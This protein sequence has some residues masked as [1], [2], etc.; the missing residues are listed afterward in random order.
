MRRIRFHQ[1]SKWRAGDDLGADPRVV[2]GEQRLVVDQDVA[3][4]GPVLELLDLVE[5]RPVV[6][7]ERV[8]GPPVALDQR[9][10]DEQL[11]G[12]LGSIRP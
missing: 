2:E 10:A 4:A 1:L 7:E 3:A 11:P 12:Q 6:V 5:Q 9:V 8:V